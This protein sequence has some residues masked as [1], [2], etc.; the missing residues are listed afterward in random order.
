M[1]FKN[2]P[3]DNNSLHV[4]FKSLASFRV[5]QT[6]VIWQ[7]FTTLLLLNYQIV[8]L[9][10]VCHLAKIHNILRSKLS[11]WT[12][13]SPSFGKIHSHFNPNFKWLLSVCHSRMCHSKIKS[14]PINV[15]QLNWSL[16]SSCRVSEKDVIKENQT[17][18]WLSKK[19][20]YD[21]RLKPFFLAVNTV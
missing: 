20:T 16:S 18:D 17:T 9:S 21:Q 8:F 6:F 4:L 14:G 2:L 15:V 3:S 5:I 19:E 7:K 13:E 11:L 12:F 10:K 1:S